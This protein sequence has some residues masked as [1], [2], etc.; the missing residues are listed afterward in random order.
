LR[1]RQL[2]RDILPSTRNL[3]G[4]GIVQHCSTYNI[5]KFI[6]ALVLIGSPEQ[7]NFLVVRRSK[8][9]LGGSI[10]VFLKF[11]KY[12]CGIKQLLCCF[13]LKRIE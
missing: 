4:R 11:L 5:V 8:Q 9:H 13:F 6:L 2:E 1:R 10:Y 3:L 12:S 7:L